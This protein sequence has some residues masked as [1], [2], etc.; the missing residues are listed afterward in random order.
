MLGYGDDISVHNAKD[1][2]LPHLVL[3][4]IG[5]GLRRPLGSTRARS[6]PDSCA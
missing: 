1:E 6:V 3:D 2:V 5:L 4:R